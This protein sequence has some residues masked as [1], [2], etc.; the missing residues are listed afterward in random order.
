MKSGNEYNMIKSIT[1]LTI[2][3]TCWF[4]SKGMAALS[5]CWIL[6]VSDMTEYKWGDGNHSLTKIEGSLDV[7]K[8]FLEMVG[9]L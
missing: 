4:F 9:G 7:S 2:K 5:R 1:Q 6:C 3:S 8:S